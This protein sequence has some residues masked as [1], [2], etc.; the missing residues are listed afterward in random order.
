MPQRQ[1]NDRFAYKPVGTTTSLTVPQNESR[2]IN[3]ASRFSLGHRFAKEESKVSL[4]ANRILGEDQ[5]EM[6]HSLKCSGVLETVAITES[7]TL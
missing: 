6:T 4:R 1:S 2:Y 5:E 7:I 3:L